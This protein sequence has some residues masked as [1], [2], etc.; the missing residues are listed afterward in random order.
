MLIQVTKLL[1]N[2][3]LPLVFLQGF[4]ERGHS[5][6]DQSPNWRFFPCRPNLPQ[7]FFTHPIHPIQL[8]NPA[9]HQSGN[10]LQHRRRRW[11]D[12]ENPE[13]LRCE[14]GGGGESCLQTPCGKEEVER[15]FF[16]SWKNMHA[17]R[18]VREEVS[19]RIFFSCPRG[20]S[21]PD[22]SGRSRRTGGPP[23][24]YVG[25]GFQKSCE[26]GKKNEKVGGGGGKGKDG[27]TKIRA[28]LV[29]TDWKKRWKLLSFSVPLRRFT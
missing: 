13:S 24:K 26:T 21:G 7:P 27:A 11:E 9:H 18:L 22:T 23:P 29:L 25:K 10:R 3:Y 5:L 6:T 15:G 20:E 8:Y 1:L 17:S 16:Y 14:V 2:L 4:F 19:I 28:E 12:Q